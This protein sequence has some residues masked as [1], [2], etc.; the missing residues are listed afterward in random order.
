M[1]AILFHIPHASTV[2]PERYL[3]D[4]L[5]CL[6][7]NIL[8]MT[9]WYTDALFDFDLGDRLVFPVSRLV[10]D[11]ERFRDDDEEEMA[12]IG[13]GAVYRTGYDLSPLR[14]AQPPDER[15]EILRTYYDPHHR[16]LERM[17]EERLARF[18]RCLILDC[19]SFHPTPLPYEK[20]G[21]RP[22][23]CLGTDDF[24]TP[25]W[26]T[27]SLARSFRRMG[28]T[29]SMNRPFAGTMVPLPQYGKDPRVLSVMIEVNRGLYM[30]ENGE[31]KEA[32]AQMKRDIGKAIRSVVSASETISY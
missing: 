18:R 17:T 15:E 23:I 10:C 1:N 8:R 29:V 14:H 12:E 28:Y 3:P 19:H 21:L 26:L 32:F 9:D 16:E 6:E 13:M 4:F 20:D 27:G 2:I 22:D 31:K 24:H 7:E 30:T 25:E 5:P 11:L